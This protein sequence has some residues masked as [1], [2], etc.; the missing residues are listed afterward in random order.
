ML[1]TNLG[2]IILTI[3]NIKNFTFILVLNLEKI[4]KINNKT[5]LKNLNII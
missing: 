1:K 5:F 2:I 3:I 4:N